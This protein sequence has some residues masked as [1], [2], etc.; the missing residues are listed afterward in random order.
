MCFL[1]YWVF[2]GPKNT[3]SSRLLFADRTSRYHYFL[4][5]W[6]FSMFKQND[7]KTQKQAIA[8]GGIPGRLTLRHLSIAE[9]QNCRAP[10]R[11]NRTVVI[12]SSESKCHF[13]GVIFC[14]VPG[15]LPLHKRR[16]ILLPR[17]AFRG[18]FQKNDT[19]FPLFCCVCDLWTSV[20]F[21]RVQGEVPRELPGAREIPKRKVT[22]W[23]WHLDAL[24]L[25]QQF[26]KF[27]C[28]RLF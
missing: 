15:A 25:F 20:A 9:H 27:G 6:R 18:A 1:V 14:H 10:Q 26:S 5:S 4:D 8:N 13:R 21:A 24:D 3:E 28:K 16:G 2:P 19:C 12:Y 7:L 22:L 17:G 11:L 23:K